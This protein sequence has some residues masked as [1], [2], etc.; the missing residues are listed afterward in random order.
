[1]LHTRLA[2]FKLLRDWLS[3]Q[4]AQRIGDD[5]LALEKFVNINYLVR[6]HVSGHCGANSHATS[7]LSSTHVLQQ[8]LARVH[9]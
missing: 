7:I 4:E 3:L 2:K 9:C 1:M 6:V 5:F 8:G